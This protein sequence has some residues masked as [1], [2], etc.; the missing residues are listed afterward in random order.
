[1]MKSFALLF[2]FISVIS[3]G[4]DN[5]PDNQNSLIG[6]WELVQFEG[7]TTTISMNDLDNFGLI[8][9][10]FEDEEFEG[11]TGSNIFFG[12]YIVESEVLIFFK[13]GISE[14][15]ESE[16]GLKFSDAIVSTYNSSDNNY[17]LFF[18]LQE[19]ILKIEYKPTEFM[20]FERQ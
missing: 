17:R 3:C 8:T 7:Q 10:T 20:Y 16:W 19:N 13:F 5:S 4:S 11:T 14:V 2:V 15:N 9:I 18:T 1:M 6:T 12:D